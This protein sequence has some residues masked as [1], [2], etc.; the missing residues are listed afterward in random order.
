MLSFLLTWTLAIGAQAW[1]V[2]TDSSDAT[3]GP[4]RRLVQGKDFATLLLLMA[5]FALSKFSAGF[6]G[7]V[8]LGL[9]GAAGLMRVL[10]AVGATPLR[11]GKVASLAF[12]TAASVLA[13]FAWGWGAEEAEA[14]ASWLIAAGILLVLAGWISGWLAETPGHRARAWIAGIGGMAL[15]AAAV[16]PAQAEAA[17]ALSGALLVLG[18]TMG[19]GLLQGRNG[20][21][22]SSAVAGLMTVGIPGLVGA[23]LL[24]VLAP[25]GNASALG[26]IGVVGLGLL[27]ST[28]LMDALRPN[29]SSTTQATSPLS[30]VAA[31]LLVV[32]GAILYLRLR[33][34]VPPPEAAAAP[35]A[36]VVAVGAALLWGRIPGGQRSRMARAFRWPVASPLARNAAAAAG[37]VVGLVRG[38]R[39]VLEGDASLLWA[40]VVVVVG[41][42]LLQ[43][44]M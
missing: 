44:V 42:L 27:G 9:L 10:S 36:L 20:A 3:G 22:V 32:L 31:G 13:A 34:L 38:A 17:L 24:G 16:S 39:D 14:V 23:V 18:G 26:W 41:L 40:L 37:A 30:S 2:G 7:Q 15:L 11:G 35:V 12:P 21:R 8:A 29:R 6:S 28:F 4:D 5:A 19:T 33:A 43:G 25:G 1:L